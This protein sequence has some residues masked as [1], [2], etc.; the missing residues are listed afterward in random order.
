MLGE[1]KIKRGL[2]LQETSCKT[3]KNKES[4]FASL[5]LGPFF[6]GFKGKI[7]PR[8]TKSEAGDIGDTNGIKQHRSHRYSFRGGALFARIFHLF[9][10]A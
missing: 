6:V 4:V 8:G 7:R 9:M 5:C 1:I 3:Y 10:E 2:G